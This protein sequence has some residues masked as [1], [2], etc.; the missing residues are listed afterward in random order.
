MQV[1][2]QP[3]TLQHNYTIKRI[4]AQPAL[5]LLLV[6]SASAFDCSQVVHSCFIQYPHHVTI[7]SAGWTEDAFQTL[8]LLYRVHEF[9]A[10][11]QL[12]P[13]LLIISTS[14]ESGGTRVATLLLAEQQPVSQI[15]TARANILQ[16]PCK[17]YYTAGAR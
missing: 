16:L 15:N 6:P 7:N 1:P 3:C 17:L 2:A 5:L 13:C 14:S 8:L 12:W 10:V 9:F 4:S 11:S